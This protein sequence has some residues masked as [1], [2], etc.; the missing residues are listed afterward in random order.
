MKVLRWLSLPVLA[1]AWNSP[2]CAVT[3]EDGTTYIA[4]LQLKLITC[5]AE[6]RIVG[7]S[8]ETRGLVV[9][10]VAYEMTGEAGLAQGSTSTVLNFDDGPHIGLRDFSGHTEIY[11]DKPVLVLDE[12]GD[13]GGDTFPW[14]I[15]EAP[16]KI[17]LIFNGLTAEPDISA[18]I[19][20]H[21]TIYVAP[22]HLGSG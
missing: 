11:E 1:M 16:Y 3:P 7:D 21:V 8:G 12:P 5:E 15:T 14:G 17:R 2:A 22:C 4:S 18:V 20:D 10:N 19:D 6:T 9:T 13:I